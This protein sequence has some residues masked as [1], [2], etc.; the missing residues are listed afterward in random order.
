[1]VLLIYVFANMHTERSIYASII[2]EH[3]IRNINS[4][5]GY[6]IFEPLGRYF[7]VQIS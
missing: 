1:M 7:N 4:L 6:L 3:A 2:E 5:R